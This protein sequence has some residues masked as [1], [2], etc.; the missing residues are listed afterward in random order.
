MT[1]DKETTTN[2]KKDEPV[3]TEWQKRNQEFLKKK[4]QDKAEQKEA[5]KRLQELRRAQFLG[6]STETEE[7]S[8]SQKIKEKK[9]KKQKQK[10]E[11]K[12]KKVK[13]KNPH[14]QRFLVVIALA[15][16]VLLFS[17]FMISPLSTSKTI[18]ILGQDHTTAE[19][20]KKASGIKNDD[21]LTTVFWNRELIANRIVKNDLWVEQAKVMFKFP[22]HF[23]IKVKEYPIIA[24]RLQK[25]I[26]YP[27]LANGQVVDEPVTKVP[28]RFLSVNL[29][30]QKEVAT[31]IKARGTLTK[32]I[33]RAIQ[34]VSNKP[35]KSTKDLVELKMYDGN[36]VRVPL[37]K[38]AERLPYYSQVVKKMQ[39]PGIIDM[40]VGI[41]VTDEKVEN[42]DQQNQST[43]ETANTETLV[44]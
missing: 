27:V 26:Y 39:V 40:E 7:E 33:R 34:S 30:T 1:K 24:Y 3:L 25:D 43:S 13:E 12:P 19:T 31:F 42:T 28:E 20:I 18:T 41:Y 35:S 36:T 16:V 21:Y 4:E 37:S 23:T 14:R 6:D 38:M 2:S 15:V 29:K 17:V 8:K 32:A 9:A 44:N 22:N 5:E 11:P 10:K